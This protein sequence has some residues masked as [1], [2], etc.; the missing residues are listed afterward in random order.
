MMT[1]ALIIFGVVAGIVA[2]VD[3]HTG[4]RLPLALRWAGSIMLG[5]AIVLAALQSA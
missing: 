2:L 4:Q 5:A 3:Q 1:S